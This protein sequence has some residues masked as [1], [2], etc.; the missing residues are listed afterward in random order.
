MNFLLRKTGGPFAF[1]AKDYELLH[2]GSVCCVLSFDDWKYVEF[3]ID[4]NRCIIRSDGK[5]SWTLEQDGINVASCKRHASGPQLEFSIE[6]DD[7]AWLFKP[8]RRKLVLGYD[9]WE[10]E[11]KI[12]RVTPHIKFWWQEIGATFNQI[13]RLEVA[14]FGVWLIGIHWVGVAGKLTAARAEIGI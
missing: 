2:T 4:G 11:V 9:I 6:F 7:R 3:V 13:P 14:G 8:N 10:G 1:F 5:A 12:G